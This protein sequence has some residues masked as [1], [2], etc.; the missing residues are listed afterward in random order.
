MEQ[1]FESNE[2]PTR[3]TGTHYV[4]YWTRLS[5]FKS[6]P[7]AWDNGWT[8]NYIAWANSLYNQNWTNLY[9]IDPLGGISMC[10][11]FMFS[12]I[13]PSAT[14]SAPVQNELSSDAKKRTIFVSSSIVP[15]LPI[16][17]V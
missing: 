8:D 6:N 4:S 9:G 2:L 3:S 16:G 11:R 17:N 15:N 13:P 5:K 10:A 7:E 12:V 14:K 1:M